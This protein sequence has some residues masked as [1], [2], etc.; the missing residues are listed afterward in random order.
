MEK[1]YKCWANLVTCRN[2]VTSCERMLIDRR[3][4]KR[5][6]EEGKDISRRYHDG[7]RARPGNLHH[8][9]GK[10]QCNNA[11]KDEQKAS[12]GGSGSSPTYHPSK[13]TGFARSE[14]LGRVP[15][16]VTTRP[17]SPAGLIAD[18]WANSSG[19]KPAK[20]KA[21]WEKSREKTGAR[22]KVV[23]I[24]AQSANGGMTRSSS[25]GTKNRSYST[26]SKTTQ[27]L[28]SLQNA[29]IPSRNAAD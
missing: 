11:I 5:R 20:R 25:N 7:I 9:Y 24:Y 27:C 2:S 10:K 14:Q 6:D 3:L 26:K 12:G 16:D 8:I 18:T 1:S 15:S 22:S 17:R 23:K 19:A 28:F 21:I 13:V 29:R 4:H